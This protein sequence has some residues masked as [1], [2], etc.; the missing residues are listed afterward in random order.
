VYAVG[1]SGLI[2]H[3]E[4]LADGRY[5]IV[6]RGLDRFRIVDEDHS[7]SYR[8]VRTAP[9]AEREANQQE[10][11]GLRRLRERIEALV[12]SPSLDSSDQPGA[13]SL[14]DDDLVNA[15]AQYLDLEAIEKQALLE[16]AGVDD[17]ARALLE[18]LEMKM[19][20]KGREAGSRT[21]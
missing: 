4:R 13:A 3:Y 2:T 9:L 7:R 21:H 19:L 10:R 12:A 8:R 15:L 17:R 20:M 6:L 16:Q 18:L 11:R 14:A 5:N 1:C